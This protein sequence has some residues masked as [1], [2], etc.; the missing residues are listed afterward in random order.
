MFIFKKG[1]L[2]YYTTLSFS[3]APKICKGAL[4]LKFRVIHIRWNKV[5][6]LHGLGSIIMSMIGGKIHLISGHFDIY[7]PPNTISFK[8]SEW[9]MSPQNLRF[10]WF[11]DNTYIK[12]MIIKLA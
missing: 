9:K 4:V 1:V 2:L 3:N 12:K 5:C 6:L 10:V 11:T 7:N 8:N